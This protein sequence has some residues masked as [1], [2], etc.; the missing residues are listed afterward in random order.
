[1]TKSHKLKIKPP[2]ASELGTLSTFLL[3]IDPVST[4]SRSCADS[5]LRI[6]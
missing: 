5:T 6:L 2:S 1:M 4:S 3:P